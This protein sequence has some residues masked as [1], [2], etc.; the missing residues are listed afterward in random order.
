[1]KKFLP[2]ILLFFSLSACNLQEP[3]EPQH[4]DYIGL[5]ESDVIVVEIFENGGAR[6]NSNRNRD[7]NNIFGRVRFRN[8]KLIITGE[9]GRCPLRIDQAPTEAFDQL[10]G[11][12]FFYMILDDIE[13]IRIR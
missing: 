5:W 13:L 7:P 8:N 3:I 12:P 2:L 4:F 1:M 9:G 10:T 6:F 11:E